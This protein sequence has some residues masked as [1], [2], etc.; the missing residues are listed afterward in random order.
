MFLD[1]TVVESSINSSYW[2][3]E[4]KLVLW[5]FCHLSEY[6]LN[7]FN[8]AGFLAHVQQF[9]RLL[10]NFQVW[11]SCEAAC[12]ILH[13]FFCLSFKMESNPL[14]D[15]LKPGFTILTIFWQDHCKM[16]RFLLGTKSGMTTCEN[17]SNIGCV[18]IK[19]LRLLPKVPAD[20]F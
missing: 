5:S 16:A 15:L 18:F 8:L 1:V 14:P 2:I 11:V 17:T 20:N 13:Q 10:D 6:T 3:Y 7:L 4:S 12:S 9:S 19:T